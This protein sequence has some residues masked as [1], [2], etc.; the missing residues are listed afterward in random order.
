ML[1]PPLKTSP[2]GIALIE[3]F[4]DFAAQPY[5]CPAGKLTTGFGH[6]ILKSEPHLR[7]AT[8]SMLQAREL[9]R[10][11]VGTVEVYLNAV[12]PAG[13]SQFRFDALVCLVFNIGIGAFDSSTLL[14]RL[15]VGNLKAAE[16]EFRK[17]VFVKG[18]RSRGLEIRRALETM[19]FAGCSDSTI[20]NE[21]ARMYAIR[22][23]G[24]NG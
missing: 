21:R 5:L 14:K 19:F 17:W 20:A 23:G 2:R 8:L 11:D 6:V 3:S 15:K 4:E 22:P 1:T 7:T 9:L 13:L 12:L 10:A 24:R 18:Q 16:D